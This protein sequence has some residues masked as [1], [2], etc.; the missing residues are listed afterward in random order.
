M[1]ITIYWTMS[2]IRCTADVTMVLSG[3]R[4]IERTSAIS[5]AIFIMDLKMSTGY[6]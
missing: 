1:I 3:E 6:T 5:S 4:E 2:K